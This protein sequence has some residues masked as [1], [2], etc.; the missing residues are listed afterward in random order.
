MGIRFSIKPKFWDSN[1]QPQITGKPSFDF[2]RIWKRGVLLMLC[3]ALVPLMALAYFDYR[4]T[5]GHSQNEIILRAD[6]LV[7]N[8]KRAV[9]FFLEERKAALQFVVQDN[10]FD[11]LNDDHRMASILKGLSSAI[12]GFTDLGLFNAAGQ[13]IRY[14]GP[15]DLKGRQYGEELWFQAVVNVGSYIS[16]VYLGFREEPHMVI[17]IRKDM[18]DGSFFVLRATLNTASFNEQLA[19]VKDSAFGDSFLINHKGVI[20]TPSL[21]Y[22]EVLS[23]F[24]KREVEQF[25]LSLPMPD[26][27]R[28]FI[29]RDPQ[30]QKIVM[31]YA[32]IPYTSF[33]LLV[34]GKED[35]LL[36]SWYNTQL[37]IITFLATSSLLILLVIPWVV[38]NLVNAIYRADSER[39]VA[40]SEAAQS[41]KLASIGRLAAGVAHEINNPLAII[42]EKAGLLGDLLNRL[43]ENEVPPEKMLGLVDS[44]RRA[45]ERCAG[46]THRL[47]SFARPG[48]RKIQEVNLAAIIGEVLEFFSKEAKLRDISVQMHIDDEL[49]P[50]SSDRGKLQ[51]VFLNLISNAF[52]ALAENGHL[53]ITVAEKD[54]KHVQIT[55]SDDGHGIDEENLKRVFEPFF[56]TKTDKGGTGL[57]LSITYGLVKELHGHIHVESTKNVGTSFVIILPLKS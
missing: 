2:R 14:I 54:S 48:E 36:Q 11:E 53:N 9:S 4:I 20:Q 28:P 3:V 21:Y 7:S 50:I 19:Y 1:A 42:N 29:T 22:G 26:D 27:A 30:G 55:I 35:E 31:G 25:R 12:G 47:L 34:V 46:I 56:S 16:E 52:A 51:Q 10:S 57:G 41:N 6:R 45:V 39:M 5:R 24:E 33:I 18:E 49:P 32:Y 15:Y 8:T 43:P 37:T 23:Q 38:T 13:Q 44:I 17:A 40:M